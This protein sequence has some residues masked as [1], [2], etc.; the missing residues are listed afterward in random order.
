MNQNEP[1][2][3][4]MSFRDYNPFIKDRD[5]IRINVDYDWRF[6]IRGF[7]RRQLVVLLIVVVGLL[8]AIPYVP[9]PGALTIIL[10]LFIGTYPGKQRF[11]TWIRQKRYFR[12][13]R[14]ILRHRYR[15][16]M[17]MPRQ[18]LQDKD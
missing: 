11:I 16:L 14:Y 3:K 18:R 2:P 15:V 13:A 4:P 9:G 8:M 1:L 7:I 10:A 17:V 6:G 5:L 12:I